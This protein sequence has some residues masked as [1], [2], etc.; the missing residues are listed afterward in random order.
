MEAGSKRTDSE[1]DNEEGFISN[2]IRIETDHSTHNK[3]TQPRP[4]D[5]Q[6]RFISRL[7]L[8]LRYSVAAN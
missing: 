5:M 8:A 1:S 2:T 4:T 6:T 7:G 3:P